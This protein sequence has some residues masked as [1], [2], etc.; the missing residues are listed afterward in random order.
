MSALP[1][2][3][4]APEEPDAAPAGHVLGAGHAL[5]GGPAVVLASR[6]EEA[7]TAEAGW[8]PGTWVLTIDP[9]HPLLGR[10]VCRAPGCQTTCAAKTGICLDCRRRLAQAGL[11]LE[12]YESLPAPRGAR[13]LGPG[14]GTCAVPGCPGHG[15]PPPGR[16]A[17]STTLISSG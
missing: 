3:G 10:S 12:E 13:W 9:G 4:P 8:D 16:Y 7:F 2:T 14:D 5:A 6:I 17:Q 1:L 11:S 15:W